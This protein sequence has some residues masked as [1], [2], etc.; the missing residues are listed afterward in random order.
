M[1]KLQPTTDWKAPE[2][3]QCPTATCSQVRSDPEIPAPPPGSPLASHL[4]H[5]PP[6]PGYPSVKQ[7]H[8]SQLE[9]RGLEGPPPQLRLVCSPASCAMCLQQSE[10]ER[11]EGNAQLQRQ[12]DTPQ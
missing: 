3:L 12:R 6:S 4:S 11:W 5:E 7:G 1:D 9:P 10:T 2:M 8:K